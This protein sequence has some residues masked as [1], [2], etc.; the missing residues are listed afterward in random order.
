MEP[1]LD[2]TREDFRAQLFALTTAILTLMVTGPQTVLFEARPRAGH[3][4]DL[5]SGRD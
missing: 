3:Q 4:R 5:P 2:R 1:K